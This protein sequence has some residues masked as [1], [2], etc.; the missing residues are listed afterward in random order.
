MKI[1]NSL[2]G[3]KEIFEPIN[4][5]QVRMYVCGMTVYDDTHIGHARTFV[6]FDLI[7][8]YLRSRNYEV[9]YIRNI[10][11]VDDKIIDRAKELKVEPAELVDRY[12]N[13]MN[14][15]FS[16]LSMIEPD[17][18]P[19]ATENID[20]IIRLIE[21]LIKKGHAY[22][23]ESDVYFSAES[24]EDYGKLSKR[25]IEDMLS[26]ARID[27]NLDKKNPV[28]FV[29]WKKDT[30]GMKWDSPWGPGRPGWH[31][32]CSAMSMDALGETFDI[33]GGGSDLKFPH[34]EN[35][36]AQSEC[37]TGKEF[38]KI[39]MHT[40]SLRIDKE[41]M[42]KSLK[43]FIT[44]KDA[45]KA[46]SAEVLRFFLISSHYRSPL[47]YSEEL[48]K[49]AKSSLDR[50]Y[51]SLDGLNL[52][53]ESTYRSE[54]SKSFTDVM[55]D[56]FNT[57]AAIAILFEMTRE[58]NNL[59]KDGEIEKANNLGSEL[60]ML[61]QSLGILQ[62]NP[63]DY[64]KSGVDLTDKEIENLIDQRTTARQNRDFALSDSIRDSLL[65]KGII[66]EDKETGTIWKKN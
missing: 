63:A 25:K 35:E 51:N 54:Y 1:F 15:D 62:K 52:D 3:K 38:A 12:I 6:A 23:G 39:W 10:T 42:S 56:D 46:N 14:E 53:S 43:N 30:A 47:N 24:F 66:L 32:E 65:E 50:I 8:R 59:K 5:N 11:D 36:I 22:V 27:I 13:S 33:H 16:S 20:S 2:T 44:I 17:D 4:P 41:K 48:L 9:K 26:G 61:S 37:V 55:D 57:P 19:R 29:L 31:I 58:I 45:L 18:Q 40:G 7:V 64:F 21:I 60:K 49:E 34:H 28:D